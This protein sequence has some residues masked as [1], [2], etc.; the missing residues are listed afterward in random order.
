[1]TMDLCDL[2]VIRPLLQEAGFRFS[3]GKG[4][5][6]LTA[7]WVPAR[8]AEA[9]DLGPGDGVVEI[10]PGVGCLTRELAARA[11]AVLAYEVDTA[12]GPVLEKTVGDLDNLQIVFG[13]VMDR[14]LAADCAKKLPGLRWSVCANLPYSITTPVLTKLY[15]AGCFERILVMV[16][17]EVARRMCAEA[18]TGDYGA[19]TLLTRWYAQ[20]ELLFTVG[21]ECFVPRPKVTSAVVRLTMRTAPPVQVDETAFFRVVRAAFNQRRKTLANALEGV[22][23]RERAAEALTACGLDGRVRGEALRLE[24]FAALT[25]AISNSRT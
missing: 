2:D 17:K 15:R 23:G 16:Q 3:K 5:N 21:P 8:I 11:G 18:G 22:C 13:D 25:N 20:P 10:G 4:Q 14:D 6:F 19:F 7:A 1:M 9:A 24:E 12:L